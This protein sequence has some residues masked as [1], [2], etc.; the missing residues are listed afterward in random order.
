MTMA[1]FILAISLLIVAACVV[2]MNWSCA[3][4]NMRDKRRAA[5]RRRS[6]VPAVSLVA[7]ALAYLLSP[8]GQ[9]MDGLSAPA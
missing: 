6:T 9:D 8:T 2:V 4:A 1:R 7:A 3:I 5:D